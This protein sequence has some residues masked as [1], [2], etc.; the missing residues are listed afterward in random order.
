M[1]DSYFCINGSGV[2]SDHDVRNYSVYDSMENSTTSNRATVTGYVNTAF[3]LLFFIIG[4]PWNTQV[5]GV[6][7]KGAVAHG[8]YFF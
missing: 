1:D 7:F 5:I 2:N 4:L 8:D 6:I 3:M